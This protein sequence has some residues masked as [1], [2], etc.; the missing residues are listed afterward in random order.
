M[1]DLSNITHVIHAWRNLGDFE[2]RLVLSEIRYGM[3]ERTVVRAECKR[4]G[5]LGSLTV[6]ATFRDEA[7]R[8]ATVRRVSVLRKMYH[9]AR[10]AAVRR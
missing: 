2:E 3:R 10:Y 1:S 8:V 5:W 6:L 9:K 4:R 7:A